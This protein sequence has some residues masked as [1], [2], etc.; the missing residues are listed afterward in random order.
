M[1]KLLLSIYLLIC[2]L[3]LSA[4][5]PTEGKITTE[6]KGEKA[7][8]QTCLDMLGKFTPYMKSIYNKDGGYFKAISAGMSNEDGV[9]TNADMAM[10]CAFLCHE[11]ANAKN[12]LRV[13][14][15]VPLAELRSMALSALRYGYATHIANRLK[16]ATDKKYWG[17][18]D[19]RYVWESSLW[20][21]SLAYAAYFL[22]DNLTAEDKSYIEKMIA[23]EADYD[24][25]REVPTGYK[26]DTKAEENGWETNVLSV[27]CAMYP[28]AVNAKAWYE[29][30]KLFASNC[31]SVAADA[32]DETMVGGKMAKEWYKGANLYDD[33]TLQNHNY[34]HT[35]Y[36]NAPI[37]E[38]AESYLALKMMQGRKMK[39]APCDNLLWNFTPVFN[40]VLKQLALADG[41][42]AMPNGNDWS[43]FLYDQLPSYTAMSTL[44]GDA[45][46]LMLENMALKYM[47]ARQTTTA[48][49]AWMQRSDIGPR[50]MGVTAHRVMM[51]YL[52]HKF[53]P[54]GKMKP[55]A[56]N[57]FQKRHAKTVLFDSQKLIRSMS[58]ERFA[59]FS[60]SDG[61][62][63]YTGIVVPCS[64]DKNKIMVPY[65]SKGTGNL[66]GY[67]DKRP[68]V[69]KGM[70]NFVKGEND[71]SVN[72]QLSI[73][74]MKD[75]K[76]AFSIYASPWNAF[77]VIDGLESDEPVTVSQEQTGLSA[78]SV[79]S[80]F[81]AVRTIYYGDEVGKIEH[82]SSDASEPTCF[83]SHWANVDNEMGVVCT[84]EKNR[85][86]FGYKDDNN[87][88]L[89]AKLYASVADTA[90]VVYSKP[91]HLRAT[92][93]YCNVTAERTKSLAERVEVVDDLPEGWYGVVVPD[94]DG[95]EYVV[96]ANLF[97]KS[98]NAMIN[99]RGKAVK[100]HIERK[101]SYFACISSLN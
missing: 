59:C 82:F 84:N 49:G 69:R 44:K 10:I 94:T 4:Q 62:K 81:N 31:Y 73:D 80:F 2:G 43:L 61:L 87:S 42:L 57:D 29:K 3:A 71:W 28:D 35:S 74:V 56:W 39:F 50:R 5:S 7:M 20:T 26:G 76:R 8:M 98:N 83:D 25:R 46:A 24:M 33:Y 55:T 32:A 79:D 92:I 45:D 65:K 22:N 48:D 1:K 18:K 17:S 21:M 72:G 78:I 12:G 90:C 30:M 38:L 96:I 101:Q 37:Q 77:V 52:L 53:F 67:Y 85:M 88:I 51:A 14:S 27:A 41:E 15:A 19:K 6:Y 54:I 58:K 13:S 86:C 16:T 95:K 99:V 60:A 63:N 11:K 97:G 66:L 40:N 47:E 23:A 100:C 75:F 64:P 89:T 70:L 34:F 91:S 93:W 9:R 68:V 36:Q